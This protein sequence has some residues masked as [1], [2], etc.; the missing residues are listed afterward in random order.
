MLVYELP[1]IYVSLS[2]ITQYIVAIEQCY[3]SG[4]TLNKLLQLELDRGWPEQC[5]VLFLSHPGHSALVRST[6]SYCTGYTATHS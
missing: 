6:T 2:T 3:V 4:G 1:C 5:Y